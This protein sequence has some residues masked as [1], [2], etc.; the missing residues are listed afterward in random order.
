MDKI[1]IG[2]VVCFIVICAFCCILGCIWEHH[3]T[4]RISGMS[5]SEKKSRYSL[6]Y[7]EQEDR[8][9]VKKALEYK[10]L[11]RALKEA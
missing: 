5:L 1:F 3:I 10:L 6:L 4:K 7:D 2:L 9:S 8:W 11:L